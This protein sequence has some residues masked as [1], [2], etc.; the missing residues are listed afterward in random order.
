[1]N[2]IKSSDVSY[3]SLTC[4]KNSE[5]TLT[6]QST[7]PTSSKPFKLL[8]DPATRPSTLLSLPPLPVLPTSPSATPTSVASVGSLN[9]HI[10]YPRVQAYRYIPAIPLPPRSS[11]QQK[12]PLPPRPGA[13]PNAKTL[14]TSSNVSRL[15]NPFAS[16]FGSRS[17]STPISSPSSTPIS[18]SSPHAHPLDTTGGSSDKNAE[19]PKD[20]DKEKDHV[21]EVSAFTIAHPIIRKDVIKGMGKCFKSQIRGA[22]ADSDV[23]TVS[24]SWVVDRTL[25]FCKNLLS[26][27]GSVPRRPVEA[28]KGSD[29]NSVLSVMSLSDEEDPSEVVQAF[30][31][32]YESLENELRS[33]IEEDKRKE[34]DR[35]KEKLGEEEAK[36]KLEKE[37]EDREKRIQGVIERVEQVLTSLFYDRLVNYS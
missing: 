21:I 26:S 1:M 34:K 14:S 17:S 6:I 36:E 33:K 16:L 32:F 3:L 12:P 35:G 23:G 10:G 37:K 13:N 15:S 25:D 31:V 27:V 18:L 19:K 11:Q 24:P 2:I 4:C 29:H 30:Q 28:S 7:L 22:L 20:I 8:L 5:N 9:S